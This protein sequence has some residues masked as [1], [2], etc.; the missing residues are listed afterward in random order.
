MHS[1]GGAAAVGLG[2]TLYVFVPR[3]PAVQ[4]QQLREAE[5]LLGSGVNKSTQI[6]SGAPSDQLL[7]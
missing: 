7:V 4:V 5:G 2:R 6:T 3:P 1:V